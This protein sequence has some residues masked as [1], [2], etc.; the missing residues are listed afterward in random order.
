[1]FAPSAIF[2]IAAA[3]LWGF[4]PAS[5]KFVIY[6]LRMAAGSTNSTTRKSVRLSCSVTKRAACS[7]PDGLQSGARSI[8]HSQAG[9]DDGGFGH[10]VARVLGSGCGFVSCAQSCGLATCG[11]V[12]E[13][14]DMKRDLLE[15]AYAAMRHDMRKTVLTMFGMAWGIA[16]VV[17][18][19][20]YGEGFGRAIQT[21]FESFGAT[22]VGV[23]P[24]RTSQQAGGNKAGVQIRFTNDDVEMLRNVVPL[25]RHIYRQSQLQSTVQNGNRFF[26]F[27]VYGTDANIRDIWNLDMESGRFLN[28]Q[29]NLSHGLYA[30]IGSEAK[31]KLF[32]GIPP[33]GETI[34]INGVSFQV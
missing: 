4:P 21:I 31:D 17:L 26:S 18:L 32:S 14:I 34:R 25:V 10:Y 12:T 33:V 19:L 16:T 28:D 22:A 1:M 2:T 3:S 29:D 5:T 6:R 24:G 15:Q 20:A 23:F 27:P 7:S 8:R 11:S 9:A 30:V 13:G